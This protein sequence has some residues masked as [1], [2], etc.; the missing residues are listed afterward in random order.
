MK[1][2]ITKATEKRLAK[3]ERNSLGIIIA[4][5]ALAVL[6]EFYDKYITMNDCYGCT[7]SEMEKLGYFIPQ[8]AFGLSNCGVKGRDAEA[9]V[10][11]LAVRYPELIT[12]RGTHDLDYVAI[13]DFNKLVRLVAE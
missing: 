12:Y 2:T 1:T 8:N 11:N 7:I 9:V 4:E 3:V 13:K 6:A 5:T 10:R